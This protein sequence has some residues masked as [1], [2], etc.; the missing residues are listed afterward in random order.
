[1]MDIKII[2]T[3]NLYNWLHTGN[4]LSIHD[5]NPLS[6]KA[7]WQIPNNTHI[8]ISQLLKKPFE[9]MLAN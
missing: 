6:K 2:T 1:M 9:M 4:P 7:A 3:Y 5:I 8:T